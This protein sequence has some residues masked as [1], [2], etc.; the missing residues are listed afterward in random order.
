MHDYLICISFPF[1]LFSCGQSHQKTHTNSIDM[2]FVLIPSGSFTMGANSEVESCYDFEEPRHR[3]TISKSFYMGRYEV[4]QEQW[5]KVMGSNPSVFKN[6]GNPVENV[7]FEDVQSFIQRLN[8]MENT[9]KYRLPTEAEWEYAARAGSNTTYFFGN[10]EE[11]L[12]HYAW[13]KKNSGGVPHPVGQKKPNEW[14]LYD[15]LGNIN[16]YVQDWFGEDYYSESPS[17]DPVGPESPTQVLT[18]QIPTEPP[19]DEPLRADPANPLSST[20]LKR[21]GSWFGSSKHNRLAFRDG[22]GPVKSDKR[23]FRLALT[24]K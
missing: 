24:I 6:P 3:V 4:T 23:G 15:V 12:E 17:V 22:I 5:E 13:Y 8:E 11:E 16:E 21:G 20:H 1:F 18:G 2:E 14:G 10:N 9:N 7:T 19:L